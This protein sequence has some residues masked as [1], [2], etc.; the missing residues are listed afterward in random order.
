MSAI[1]QIEGEL[2][3]SAAQKIV[4]IASRFNHAI[5]DLLVNGAITTLKK[6][7]AVEKQITL[8][9]VPGAFEIPMTCRQVLETRQPSGIITLG[10]V[11]R[12]A[13]PHFDFICAD[14]A[15]GIG[16]LSRQY[17]TPISFGV[18]TVDSIDQAVERSG[19]KFGNKGI[20]AATT[21][22][23]MMNLF[24]RLADT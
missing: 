5:V 11:I 23:E 14:C 1:E 9:Q 15:G 22:I 19:M 7:G 24:Q 13:T 17:Q 10:A 21:L 20:E 16:Q 2:S 4:V 8:V 3:I 18:L 6:H 12:G